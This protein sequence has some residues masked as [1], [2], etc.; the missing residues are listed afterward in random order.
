MSYR[1]W[2]VC[3]FSFLNW[4]TVFCQDQTDLFSSDEAKAFRVRDENVA[5]NVSY[6]NF[7]VYF[8]RCD[9]N[10]DPA[11]DFI[12]GSV[13]A[14][15]KSLS[16]NQDKIIFDCS[17]SLVID[18]VMKGSF[19]FNFLHNTDLCE[20]LF[21]VNLQTG[22]IDSVQIF[23]HGQPAETGN[24]SFISAMHDN[25]PVIWTLSEPYGARDW[26]PCRQNC[27]DKIDSMEINCRIPI[28]NRCGS[29]GKLISIDTISSD[30][31]Y[32]WK[33]NYPI[34]PYLV[35]IGVTNY[36][37]VSTSI[38]LSSNDTLPI[39]NFIYPEHVAAATDGIDATG[40]LILFFDSL[41]TPY[42]FKQEKYGHTEF[43]WGGG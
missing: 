3:L 13:T 25:Q 40:N 23:Y 8:S 24:G 38:I 27:A 14:Y 32:H 2:F 43:G 42:P 26:W 34:A 10:V 39:T 5:S 36:S 12:A 15:F 16:N 11:V 4:T 19:H 33:T 30:V 35:A 7:D 22:D 31:V 37:D 28:G 17:D 1:F 9:W 29:N 18:S 6:G 21:P 20:I 41:L